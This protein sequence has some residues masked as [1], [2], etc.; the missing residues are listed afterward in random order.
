MTHSNKSKKSTKSPAKHALWMALALAGM[1]GPLPQAIAQDAGASDET[2]VL[3]AI[4][5]IG[6][7]RVAP[8]SSDT[9]SVVPVDVVNISKEVERSPRRGHAKRP[10]PVH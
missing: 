10:V 9:D 6:S 1:F 2:V 7:R 3:D 4:S 8:R 5:V